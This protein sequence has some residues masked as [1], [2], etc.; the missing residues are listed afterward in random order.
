M[1]APPA[2]PPDCASDVAEQA[3]LMRRGRLAARQKLLDEIGALF[4]EGNS[5]GEIARKLGLDYRRVERWVRRIDLPD[6]NTMVSTPS[7]PAISACCWSADGRR[8]SPRFV[9]C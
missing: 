9:T 4:E 1:T 5:I 7:N 3:R 6:R 8:A 2:T